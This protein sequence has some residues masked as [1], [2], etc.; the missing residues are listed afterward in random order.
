[1]TAAPVPPISET[2]PHL[3]SPTNFKS[4]K[5]QPVV[6]DRDD[7]LIIP[8]S[9]AACLKR[10]HRK[11]NNKSGISSR[12]PRGGTLTVVLAVAANFLQNEAPPSNVDG[13]DAI[14]NLV[15]RERRNSKNVLRRMI[16]FSSSKRILCHVWGENEIIGWL[17]FF[18]KLNGRLVQ[19]S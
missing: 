4:K 17:L 16:F 14:W 6:V 11:I 9:S 10:P 8:S 18:A 13:H 3:I 1:M 5:H 2:H 19:T 7:L 15:R 12:A